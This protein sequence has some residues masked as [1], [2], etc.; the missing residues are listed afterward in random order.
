MTLTAPVL[1]LTSPLCAGI[2]SDASMLQRAS[3]ARVDQPSMGVPPFAAW[4]RPTRVPCATTPDSI[5]C[6]ACSHESIV[7]YGGASQIVSRIRTKW[8]GT[9]NNERTKDAYK[10][11]GASQVVSR[12][13]TKWNGTSN[14]HTCI[15]HSAEKSA[16]LV[17]FALRQRFEA[18]D[19][20]LVAA[21]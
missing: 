15:Q 19:V 14:T 17:L 2:G 21:G 13:R 16:A 18:G 8:N 10:Y 5:K 4:I 12:I 1:A 6:R 11:G 9:Q 3:E 20:L 7:Q